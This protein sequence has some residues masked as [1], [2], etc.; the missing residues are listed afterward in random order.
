MAV[1]LN[2]VLTQPYYRR[3]GKRVKAKRIKRKVKLRPKHII[4]SFLLLAGF[5][6][7]IQQTY[8]FLITWD[9]L[10]V[11]R[12]EVRS[13]KPELQNRIQHAMNRNRLG[14]LL[15]LDI[16]RIQKVIKSH[17]WIKDVH[18]KK[19]FPSSVNIQVIERVPIAVIKTGQYF[20][21]DKDGTLIQEVNVSHVNG[22]PLITDE[23]RFKD[24]YKDKFRLAVQFLES[25]S[26]EQK[27]QIQT[28]DLSKHNCV[29]VKLK[30]IS[31]WLILGDSHFSGK[32]EDYMDKRSYFA[33]FGELKSINMSFEDR[34]I[35]A[36]R[37]KRPDNQTHN[38]EKEE[39]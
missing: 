32:F 22:L 36:P 9:K 15:L 7:L 27:A 28:I 30:N 1:N 31:P 16:N 34:Y 20:L 21:I 25:L 14:N 19:V 23:N 11:D 18:V 38:S 12:I 4:L 10:E 26:S 2:P 8:L 24:G 5:F 39:S 29:S 3:K 13:T 6:L 35:L 33:Q 37:K 17:I